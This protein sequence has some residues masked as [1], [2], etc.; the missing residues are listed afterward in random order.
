MLDNI[1]RPVLL[2]GKVAMNGLLLFLSILGGLASF[3]FI[4]LILGP[5]VMAAAVSLMG[6]LKTGK[7]KLRVSNKELN[8][9][10][11]N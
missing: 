1:L 9:G 10:H 8:D 6:M 5:V 3:G 11:G 4:G 7:R 2:R